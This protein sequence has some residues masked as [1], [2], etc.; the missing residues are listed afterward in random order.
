M[1]A[2]VIQKRLNIN[3]GDSKAVRKREVGSVQI[4][5]HV[6]ETDACQR[7]LPDVDKGDF[8]GLAAGVLHFNMDV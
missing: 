8:P 7:E 1:L 2:V 5:T 3:I 4:R 6:G